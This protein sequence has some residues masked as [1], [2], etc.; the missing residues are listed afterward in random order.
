MSQ[1]RFSRKRKKISLNIDAEFLKVIDEIAS[2][3]K[4]SRN[5]IIEAIVGQG[6]NP[7]FSY[8]ENTWKKHSKEKWDKKGIVKKEIK[9]LLSDLKKIRDRHVWLKKGVYKNNNLRQFA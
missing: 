5:L 8:L 6:M 2:L 3:T 4:N 9:K 7:F 1:K